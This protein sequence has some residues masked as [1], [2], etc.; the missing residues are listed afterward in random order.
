MRNLREYLWAE[1]PNEALRLFTRQPGRGAFLGGGTAL[2]AQSDPAL[3][4]V[5]DVSR[6]GI[7][8]ID[9][10]PAELVI[11]AA[12]PLQA[13]FE[14][15]GARS[16][17]GGLLGAAVAATRTEPWRRQATIAGRLLEGDPTDRV[18]AAL[19]VLGAEATIQSAADT[20]PARVP[21]ATLL[22]GSGLAAGALV[23]SIHVPLPGAG[24]GFACEALARAALDAPLA[25]VAVG[26][27]VASGRIVE[28]RVATAGLPLPRRATATEAAL[29]G[30]R[31]DRFDTAQDALERDLEPADDWRASAATRTHLG[32]V[33]LGRALRR[34]VQAATGPG[35]RA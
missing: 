8:T 2:T 9:E 10:T 30:A 17:A 25:V 19:L 34:A 13:V 27:R 23:L 11:G 35:S 32:R 29:R 20:P 3:D 22:P 21:I 14:S 1:S 33:L 7:G 12:T 6:A 15:P 16:L 18:A 26:A 5:I 28:A 24:W 4:F 31:T